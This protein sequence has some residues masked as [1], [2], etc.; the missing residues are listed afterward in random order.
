MIS[1]ELAREILERQERFIGIP[2]SVRFSNY[3]CFTIR[4][5]YT[6]GGREAELFEKMLVD[7]L[8]TINSNITLKRFIVEDFHDSTELCMN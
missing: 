2:K 7:W 3:Y 6:I 1:L 8:I 5:I 4:T